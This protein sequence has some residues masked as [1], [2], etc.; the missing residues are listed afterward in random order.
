MRASFI[1]I[2]SLVLTFLTAY[3]LATVTVRSVKPLMAHSGFVAANFEGRSIPKGVGIVLPLSALPP[4]GVQL[5][6]GGS[7]ALVSLW[8][9][10]LCGM[11]LLGLFDDTAGDRSH[12]GFHQ[13]FRALLAGRATTGAIKA[14]YG[15]GLGLY[16]GWALSGGSLLRALVGAAVI[17][18]ATNAVNLLDVRPGRA[19]KGQ[20]LLALAGAVG[21]LYSV[22][23]P[24]WHAQHLAAGTAVA[25]A[26][27]A[28]WRG[29]LRGE[30]ML[31]D[32]GSNVL[33][34]AGGMLIAASALWWQLIWLAALAWVHV[35]A[36]RRSLTEVIERLP[37]LDRLDRW[38]RR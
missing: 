10:V 22:P 19:L 15:G 14:L 29:D 2:S 13:H 32:A 31:G 6:L 37:W 7:A 18:L 33:G 3:A 20:L 12:G 27:M 36:E 35:Y 28:L 16:A 38:G 24:Q 25:G 9:A 5:W 34:A 8:I 30:H 17:A 26:S 21:M 11:G 4:I 23:S 1:E